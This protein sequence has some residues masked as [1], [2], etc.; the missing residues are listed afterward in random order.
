MSLS[1][2]GVRS[3]LAVNSWLGVINSNL[4]GSSR[5]GFKTIRPHL[6]DGPSGLG[7]LGDFNQL[8]APP[9]TLNVQAT[10]IEWAQGS[11]VNSGVSTHFALQ[12]QGFFVVADAAGRYYL[13]RD[14]EFHWDGNGYLVNSAGL[15]VVS[16]GQDFI[17][18]DRRDRS[19]TFRLDGASQELLRYGDKSLLVVD[20]ANRDGL[21]M[22]QYGST[23]LSVDGNLPL[24]LRNDFSETTDGFSFIY[25]DPLQQPLITKSDF[26]PVLALPPVGYS[27]DFSIDFGDNG[28]MD[29]RNFNPLNTVGPPPVILEFDH[30]QNTIAHIVQAINAY[31]ATVGNRVSAYFDA[32]LDRLVINN[33]QDLAAF[34]TPIRNT[35]IAFLGANGSAIRQFFRFDQNQPSA[36]LYDFDNDTNLETIFVSQRPIDNTDI[37]SSL[38]IT[39][40]DL[41]TPLDL[42]SR[43]PIQPATYSHDKSNGFIQSD[44]RTNGTALGAMVIG[45]SQQTLRFDLEMQIKISNGPLIFGFGQNHAHQLYSNGFHLVYDSTSGSLQLFESPATSEGS[46]RLLQSA[47][48]PVI[49]IGA[50]PTAVNPEHRLSIVM[51]ENRLLSVTL[52]GQQATFNLTGSAYEAVGY[53]SLRNRGNILQVHDLKA[54]FYQSF[55]TVRTGEMISISPTPY[56]TPEITDP[57]QERV[58]TRIVQASLESSTASL[59]EYVPLLA[60]VQKVFASISKVIS[61][62]NAMLDDMNSLLR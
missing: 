52:N 6:T 11:I 22:S 33:E 3:L 59:T 13:T 26:L 42:F 40:A 48:L 20:V 43:N 18:M 54:N 29:F 36:P 46:P 61:A 9:A 4:Q 17:R 60:L 53:L 27:T 51:D 23:I 31:G 24:R 25:D 28:A 5:T 8:F 32:D 35:Q 21:M 15:R 30:T 10:S 39:A 16:S 19:D 41:N 45:E 62:H 7:Y 37:L 50:M 58:R 12:G 1:Q 2:V 55:N 47:I 57:W 14:G 38:D 49:A 34:P 44:A 56:S